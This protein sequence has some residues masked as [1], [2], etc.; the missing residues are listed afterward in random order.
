[1]QFRKRKGEKE[2]SSGTRCLLERENIGRESSGHVRRE[3]RQIIVLLLKAKFI[4]SYF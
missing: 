1:M 2:Y 3:N 4:G